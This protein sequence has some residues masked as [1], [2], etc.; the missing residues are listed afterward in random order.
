[1]WD[2]SWYWRVATQ[3]YFA[4]TPETGSNL[5]FC[6]LYPL[7]IRGLMA[8]FDALG[9]QAGV[10]ELQNGDVA[11]VRVVDTATSGSL[12]ASVW[13]FI[14]SALTKRVAGSLRS[15]TRNP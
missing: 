9:I 10:P 6:P 12:R 7:L 11:T 13:L 1:M 15:S 3:G 2:A 4:W 8:G 5:A 14:N